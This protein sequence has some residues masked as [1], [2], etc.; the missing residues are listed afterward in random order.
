MYALDKYLRRFGEQFKEHYLNNWDAIRDVCEPLFIFHDIPPY[1]IFSSREPGKV[2]KVISE[3]AIGL[4]Y[5]TFA[6][7]TALLDT[8]SI[9]RCIRE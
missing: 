4:M 2:E 6:F 1:D 7:G 3:L 8:P 9:I 5:G